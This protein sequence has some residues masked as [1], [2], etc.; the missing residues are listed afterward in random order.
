MSS[1]RFDIEIED[2]GQ[3]HRGT[4]TVNQGVV[5]VE[6]GGRT[7]STQVGGSPPATLARVLLG[8]LVVE[9]QKAH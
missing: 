1:Q 2:F 5:T 3:Q 8:E 6:Y 7:K 9:A 4:Y